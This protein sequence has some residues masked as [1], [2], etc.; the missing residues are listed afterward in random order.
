[1]TETVF[2]HGSRR[3]TVAEVGPG[4]V[5]R[6]RGFRRHWRITALAGQIVTMAAVT[7]PRQVIEAHA[8]DLQVVTRAVAK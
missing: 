1:M 2:V 7:D 8:D 6:R 3:L 4:D 5:V